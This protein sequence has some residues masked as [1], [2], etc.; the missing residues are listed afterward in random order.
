MNKSKLTLLSI[1][2]VLA[3]SG[4][5]LPALPVQA[6]DSGNSYSPQLPKATPHA[7]GEKA[8]NPTAPIAPTT[9]GDAPAYDYV[10]ACRSDFKYHVGDEGWTA[11]GNGWFEA[12]SSAFTGSYPEWWNATYST[13][14]LTGMRGSMR[15]PLATYEA[16]SEWGMGFSENPG[17]CGCPQDLEFGVWVVDSTMH[18]ISHGFPLTGQLDFLPVAQD[19]IIEIGIL[20]ADSMWVAYS[21]ADTAPKAMYRYMFPT[22]G[23]SEPTFRILENTPLYPEWFVYNTRGNVIEF[24]KEHNEV[25]MCGLD[26]SQ[27]AEKTSIVLP[28]QTEQQ[29]APMLGAMLLMLFALPSAALWARI[30]AIS[31][32]VLAIAASL[33]TGQVGFYY[34]YAIMLA[35]IGVSNLI[36]TISGTL[37]TQA[38]GD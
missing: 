1:I 7:N 38:S 26:Y 9:A 33:V 32:L 31:L 8:S 17:Y 16:G 12:D 28:E 37:S 6:I 20:G 27:A 34:A 2:T 4:F 11:N 3:I 35:F 18:V 5:A 22:Q 29:G 30:T 36:Q 10:G 15:V 24:G 19:N 14:A 21:P 23:G 13:Q 25:Q